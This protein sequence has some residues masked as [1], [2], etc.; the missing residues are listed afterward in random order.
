[1]RDRTKRMRNF[2]I[3]LALFLLATC[4][5]LPRG[6]RRLIQP[7]ASAAGKTF[8]VDTTSDSADANAGDGVCQTAAGKCS[9]RAAIE[10][11]NAKSGTYT[12]NF[13]IAGTGLKTIT[14]NSFGLA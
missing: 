10:E 12:I 9:L 14:P 13:N 1:M 2:I 4:L 5:V 7:A 11:S 8:I 6:L 3:V